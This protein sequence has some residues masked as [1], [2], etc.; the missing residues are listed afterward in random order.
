MARRPASGEIIASVA[1]SMRPEATQKLPLHIA[2]AGK[3]I[4][5]GEDSFFDGDDTM[6][7]PDRTRK[8]KQH[9]GKLAVGRYDKLCG[10]GWQGPAE[11]YAAHVKEKHA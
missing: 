10:C 3:R 11:Q 8:K 5:E 2:E 6:T 4:Q 9:G 1:E 7:D